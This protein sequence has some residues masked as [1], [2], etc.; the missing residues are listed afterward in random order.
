MNDKSSF[1]FDPQTACLTEKALFDYIDGRLSPA[2]SHAVEKHL[3]DCAFC[4]EA[5][6]GL[7]LLQD[8]IGYKNVLATEVPVVSLRQTQ[9]TAKRMW[10]AAAALF[11]LLLGSAVVYKYLLTNSEHSNLVQQNPAS[12]ENTLVPPLVRVTE[13]DA[14]KKFYEPY[15][16]QEQE[17]QIDLSKDSPAFTYLSDSKITTNANRKGQEGM[18]PPPPIADLKQSIP[19][20]NTP[21]PVVFYKGPAS[22]ATAGTKE[23]TGSNELVSGGKEKMEEKVNADKVTSRLE[24]NENAKVFKAQEPIAV[25]ESNTRS[26]TKKTAEG[27]ASSKTSAASPASIGFASPALKQDVAKE[28]NKKKDLNDKDVSLVDDNMGSYEGSTRSSD[29]TRSD[30]KVRAQA[31]TNLPAQPS[32]VQIPDG[33]LTA[34]EETH[35]EKKTGKRDSTYKVAETHLS[36]SLSAKNTDPSDAFLSSG[37]SAYRNKNYALALDKFAKVFLYKPNHPAA[38]FY[39]G[40][41]YLALAAPDAKS[42]LTCLDQLLRMAPNEFTY[43]AK[44]YKALAMIKDNKTGEAKVLLDQLSGQKGRYAAGAQALSAEL[45]KTKEKK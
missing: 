31:S 13:D 28:T 6:E 2:L 41:S 29:S 27:G 20:S 34:R 1:L 22:D 8:R 21:A 43:P 40:V 16:V 44:W 26:K 25:A 35:A 3:L 12:I 23:V 19:A 11:V 24:E 30:A 10:F 42:A 39:S 14:F 7:E 36:S 9:P 38:L 18:F 32:T 37:L 17:R 45:D 15:P 33:Y 5:L 4:A